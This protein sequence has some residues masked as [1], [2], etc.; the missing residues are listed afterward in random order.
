MRY[1]K[2]GVRS[3]KGQGDDPVP[4]RE[5]RDVRSDAQHGAGVLISHHVRNGDQRSAQSI[6]RVATFDADHFDADQHLAGTGNRGRVP[7]RSER[8]SARRSRSKPRLSWFSSF[9]RGRPDSNAQDFA[10]G[11][12]E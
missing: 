5:T 9:S 4:D 3:V 8:R 1:A 11:R 10:H 7:L 6:K 2:L 12:E